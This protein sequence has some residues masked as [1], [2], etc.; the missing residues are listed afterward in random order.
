MSIDINDR[1]GNRC[2]YSTENQPIYTQMFTNPTSRTFTDLSPAR[3]LRHH[4]F[5]VNGEGAGSGIGDLLTS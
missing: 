3:T 1:E 4:C 5:G 2:F